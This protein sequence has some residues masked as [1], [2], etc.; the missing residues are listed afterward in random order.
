MKIRNFVILAFVLVIMDACAPVYVPNVVNVPMFNNQHETH[1][2]FHGALSGTNAQIAYAVTNNIGVM[3]N[4]CYENRFDDSSSY[5]KRKFVEFGVGY[6]KA[7]TKRK[8]V[9]TIK[10]ICFSDSVIPDKT[11][12]FLT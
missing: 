4:A 6:Y 11:I 12:Y 8:V 3:V 1:A 2:S 5:A 7:F 9:N 10:N